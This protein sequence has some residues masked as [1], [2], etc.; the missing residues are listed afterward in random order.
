[1]APG[2][3]SS[4]KKAEGTQNDLGDVLQAQSSS[5]LRFI[6]Y[7]GKGALPAEDICQ[8]VFLRS[9]KASNKPATEE[10][11]VAWLFRIARN[12]VIDEVRKRERWDKN[13]VSIHPDE[14]GSESLEVLQVSPQARDCAARKELESVLAEALNELD[15]T[16]L[17]MIALR[18]FA[19]LSTTQV[20]KTLSI[21][22][23]TVCARIF[24]ATKK[25]RSLIERQGYT[26]LD[27]D[28]N[29]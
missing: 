29:G 17:E 25:M 18:F 20:S 16:S 6:R 4:R 2:K 5:L 1:M 11:I 27:L 21:P 26:P 23:G 7:L 13:L 3:M 28:Y 19:G 22:V 8:E 12:C 24:R 15:E 9:L 14:S 10:E